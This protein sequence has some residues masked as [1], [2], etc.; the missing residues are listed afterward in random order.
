MTIRLLRLLL[1]AAMVLVAAGTLLG[2]A[3][4]AQGAF[5]GTAA[6][7]TLPLR[8]DPAQSSEVIA[9]SSDAAAGRLVLDHATLQVCAGGPGYAALQALDI[10]VTSG[11]WLL[12]MILTLKLVNQVASGAPFS[13]AAVSR[14]RTVGAAMIALSCWMWLRMILLP[15]ILLASINPVSGDYQIL[16]TVAQSVEGMRN[17][18]VDTHFGIGLLAAGLIILLLSEAFRIGADLREDSESI[19]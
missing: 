17:A 2:L 3:S 13:R 9:R 1:W 12:M 10:V 16:P 18:R 8:I 19:V 4:V 5:D 14:L 11:L 7:T 15:P 6:P